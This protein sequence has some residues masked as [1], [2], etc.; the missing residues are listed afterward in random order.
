MRSVKQQAAYDSRRARIAARRQAAA[1]AANK[2]QTEDQ[3]TSSQDSDDDSDTESDTETEVEA[4]VD[5]DDETMNDDADE[6]PLLDLAPTTIYPPIPFTDSVDEASNLADEEL[7]RRILACQSSL[8][9][10]DIIYGAPLP[11][12]RSEILYHHK[13]RRPLSIKY[14]SQDHGH[15]YSVRD[16]ETGQVVI[17]EDPSFGLTGAGIIDLGQPAVQV[18]ETSRVKRKPRKR[19]RIA[20]ELTES[21]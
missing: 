7:D 3:A 19:A 4:E 10:F 13:T 18:G 15:L 17:T 6:E 20:E 14:S 9:K 12:P 1:I 5:E 16:Q 21:V 8:R 2:I 11:D